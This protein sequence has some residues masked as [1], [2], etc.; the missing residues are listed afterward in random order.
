MV[1]QLYKTSDYLTQLLP[2]LA[3]LAFKT[4]TRMLDLTV[5]FKGEYWDLRYHFCLEC[6]E[7]FNHIFMCNPKV[8]VSRCLKEFKL[9]SFSSI[10]ILEQ[11]TLFLKGI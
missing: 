6:D 10:K 7:P 11:L 9:Q 8:R 4:K 3:R 2:T 5:N 1:Y